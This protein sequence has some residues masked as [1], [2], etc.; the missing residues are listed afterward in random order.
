[1]DIKSEIV[2]ENLSKKIAK[3]GFNYPCLAKYSD[4]GEIIFVDNP[5]IHIDTFSLCAPFW[6]QVFDWVLETHN[7]EVQFHKLEN[8]IYYVSI[9]GSYVV[10]NNDFKIRFSKIDSKIKALEICL[11]K[12]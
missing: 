5:I 2:P 1:M 6:W 11:N 12:I 3:L 7:V 10:D 4:I 8:N 9:N